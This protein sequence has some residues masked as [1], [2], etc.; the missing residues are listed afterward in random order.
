MASPCCR[1]R[2]NHPMPSFLCVLGSGHP[3][4]TWHQTGSILEPWDVLCGAAIQL[5]Q[6][7]IYYR[8]PRPPLPP[9]F[10][11]GQPPRPGS[12]CTGLVSPG[13]CPLCLF[14]FFFSVA[15]FHL[16]LFIKQTKN[17]IL[18]RTVFLDPESLSR[19]LSN[20][21]VIWGPWTKRL[22]G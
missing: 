16:Y 18:W 12:A 19:E 6:S 3:H 20:K 8:L 11:S 10:A 21:R 2:R 7:W 9:M 15:D 13:L 22:M 5:R 4:S 17:L 14:F 1:Q